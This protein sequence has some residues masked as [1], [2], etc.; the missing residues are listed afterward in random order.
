ML[1]IFVYIVLL[2][3]LGVRIWP[4]MQRVVLHNDPAQVKTAVQASQMNGE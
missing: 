4:Y 3:L 2:R 1:C